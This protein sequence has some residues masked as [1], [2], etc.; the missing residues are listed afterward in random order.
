MKTVSKIK[1]V[2]PA[3]VNG[4]EMVHDLNPSVGNV[5]GKAYPPEKTS[6]IRVR[7]GKAQTKGFMARGPMG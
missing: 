4:R 7:G 6:G 3:H 5:A 1:K 2:A